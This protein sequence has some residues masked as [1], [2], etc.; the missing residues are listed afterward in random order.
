M[1]TGADIDQELFI[2]P[3]PKSVCRQPIAAVAQQVDHIWRI[4]IGAGGLIRK[5]A[6]QRENNNGFA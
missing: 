1:G 6:P 4:R 3:T 2:D 5:T